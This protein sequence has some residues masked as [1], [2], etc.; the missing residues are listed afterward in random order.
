M[1]AYTKTLLDLRNTA[2]KTLKNVQSAGFRHLLDTLRREMTDEY[3]SEVQK[4]LNELKNEDILFSAK[5]GGDLRIV[6]YTL[7]RMEKGS[8]LRWRLSPSYTVKSEER[9][10]EFEDLRRRRGH[11]VSEAKNILLQA[12]RFLQSFLATLQRTGFYV[13]CQP[14]R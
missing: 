3:F 10:Y 11:A 6:D 2:E 1:A 13:G 9:L 12:A 4:H 7:R 5:L 14:G 8:W